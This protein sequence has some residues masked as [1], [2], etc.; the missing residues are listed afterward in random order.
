M[1]GNKKYAG[2]ELIGL[3]KGLV[4]FANRDGNGF[5]ISIKR[6]QG[7]RRWRVYSSHFTPYGLYVRFAPLP[8]KKASQEHPA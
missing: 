4:V 8:P 5:Y 7:P 1:T 6:E 3:H 2:A